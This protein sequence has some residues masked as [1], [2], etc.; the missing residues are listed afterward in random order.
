MIC[1]RMQELI[2]YQRC[3]PSNPPDTSF[4]TCC[5]STNVHCNCKYEKISHNY[6]A[7][8]VYGT[9][10]D[11]RWEFVTRPRWVVHSAQRW[12]QFVALSFL[13][14]IPSVIIL[15]DDNLFKMFVSKFKIIW[16]I[17]NSLLQSDRFNLI[18]F[19]LRK[20]KK[21]VHVS[22]YDFIGP[23]NECLANRNKCKIFTATYSPRVKTKGFMQR[24]RHRR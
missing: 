19:V 6:K 21:I 18:F 10:V 4:Q 7:R 3:V 5:H 1:R 13:R 23:P 17:K 20:L 16:D 8:H 14:I 24:I 12:L 15:L 22:K 2:L 11:A 9:S